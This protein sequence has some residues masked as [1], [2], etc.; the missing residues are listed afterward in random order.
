MTRYLKFEQ[1]SRFMLL[2][3][4]LWIRAIDVMSNAYPYAATGFDT[5]TEYCSKHHVY[6]FAQDFEYI[7]V[8]DETVDMRKAEVLF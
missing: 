5:F 3:L 6:T 1:F 2:Y 8:H 7:I 4:N